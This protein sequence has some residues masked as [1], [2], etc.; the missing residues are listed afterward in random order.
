M[1]CN[2]ALSSTPR[3]SPNRGAI[4]DTPAKLESLVYGMH[5]VSGACVYRKNIH[6]KLSMQW[7][8]VLQVPNV[9]GACITSSPNVR[10]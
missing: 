6:Y 7:E 8:R 10:A 3:F 1:V 9:M 2:Y 4:I 5:Y